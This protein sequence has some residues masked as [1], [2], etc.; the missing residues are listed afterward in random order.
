[1][2]K[3]IIL[4]L[5]MAWGSVQA[6]TQAVANHG[7]V[8]LV[9]NIKNFKNDNGMAYI[10]LQDPNNKPVQKTAARIS[11]NTTQVVFKNLT[12]GKYAV[13][14]FHDKND[15]KVMDKGIFGMPKESWGVSNNVKANFGPPKFEDTLFAV[16]SDKTISITMN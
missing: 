9:V 8:T 13:R 1:M 3:L 12:L 4:S 2:K 11:N 10:T 16:E 5:C 6:Q 14:L 7:T 15:N